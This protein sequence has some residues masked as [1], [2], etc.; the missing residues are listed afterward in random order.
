MNREESRVHA[1][2]NG[3][4]GW[5][6][7]IEPSID[8]IRRVESEMVSVHTFNLE[9]L[10]PIDCINRRCDRLVDPP[11][12]VREE[13]PSRGNNGDRTSVVDLQG[14]RIGPREDPVVIDEIARVGACI[15]VD[16]L[17]VIA[18]TEYVELWRC[19]ESD[20]EQIGAGEVL[21]LVD[22]HVPASVLPSVPEFRIGEQRLDRTVDLF[23]EVGFVPPDQSLPVALVHSCEVRNVIT[24]ALNSGRR[25]QGDADLRQGFDVRTDRVRV[26]SPGSLDDP[27]EDGSHVPF[28]DQA[29]SGAGF[30]ENLPSE[31]VHGA[32]Q[33]TVCRSCPLP[34][35]CR[36][37]RVVCER[38]DRR[39][40]DR[41]IVEEMA[42][43]GSERPGLAGPGRSDDPCRSRG[44]VGCGGLVGGESPIDQLL[45][46]HRLEASQRHGLGVHD[47]IARVDRSPGTT[48]D[49]CGCSVR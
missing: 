16:R 4:V 1:S 44:V 49:P 23:V 43:T 46:R 29:H 34:Q 13:V 37:L 14:M 33:G 25:S 9:C 41:P 11:I 36:R 26:G 22:E 2:Q 28:V 38:T 8:P 45:S 27:V 6:R 17:I 42:E 47:R 21:E 32:D 20:E 18:D 30:S 5:S 24:S 39:R 48:V 7:V 40:F 15:S 31:R 19:K 3:D 10:R 12:V 35:L